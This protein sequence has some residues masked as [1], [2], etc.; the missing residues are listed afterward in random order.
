[1]EMAKGVFRELT[2]MRA[3][4]GTT[5]KV[6]LGT[7]W[8]DSDIYSSI[9]RGVGIEDW[10][11][12]LD[13]AVYTTPYWKVYLR[14]AV[15]P[16]K[17]GGTV[18]IGGFGEFP[19]SRTVFPTLKE[20]ELNKIYAEPTMNDYTFSCQFM[21]NPTISKNTEFTNE[22]L[23]AATDL[24]DKVCEKP[25]VR[26]FL[27]VDPAYTIKKRSDFTAFIYCGYDA[28]NILQVRMALKEKKDTK[29]IVDT[30]FSM[31][32]TFHPGQVGIEA[33][34][35]QI[36]AKWV[37]DKRTERQQFFKITEIKT[38]PAK[39]KQ[40]RIRALKALFKDGKIAISREFEDLLQ[41]F[42]DF[43]FGLHDDL[44]DCLSFVLDK[45]FQKNPPAQVAVP[46]PIG[47]G[48]FSAAKFY[49]PLGDYHVH[50]N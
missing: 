34:G 33:N 9:V 45:V 19:N 27:L 25:L 36:L 7:P 23:K 35:T 32:G 18:T 11:I 5:R 24:Y 20:E 40:V 29:D 16:D 2:N 21:C 17:N 37:R 48:P 13:N 3:V 22:N 15:E 50:T 46:E 42:S 12:L 31:Q 6:V 8:L 38:G 44:I 4:E 30:I 1:I 26:S 47:S 10:K 28:D 49:K 14:S 39:S 43:P 41:E